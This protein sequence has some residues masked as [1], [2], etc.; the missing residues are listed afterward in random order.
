[1]INSH[2][3]LLKLSGK[4]KFK[5]KQKRRNLWIR[6]LIRVEPINLWPIEN[7]ILIKNPK[8]RSFREKLWKSLKM[9]KMP[10]I[11]YNKFHSL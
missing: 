9:K 3:K 6:V 7:D 1:M 8:K 5:I 10:K 2:W 4:R 11:N